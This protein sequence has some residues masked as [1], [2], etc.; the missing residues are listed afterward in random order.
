MKSYKGVLQENTTVSVK[1][2]WP[3]VFQFSGRAVD[4][5]PPRVPSPP[6]PTPSPLSQKIRTMMA[7]YTF[8]E[9]GRFLLFL[10]RE[11]D[12][13]WRSLYP[14]AVPIDKST[15]LD[16]LEGETLAERTLNLIDR[17]W[18]RRREDRLRFNQD[19]AENN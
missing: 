14:S 9:Q 5:D 17:E 16:G 3:L 11:D 6:I 7:D 4:L 1:L 12:G 10:K 15:L 19:E 2:V 13:A 18:R 8:D